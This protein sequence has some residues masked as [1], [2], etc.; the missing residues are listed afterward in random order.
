MKKFVIVDIDGTL[1]VPNPERMK[2]AH[3]DW[4]AFYAD[5][6]DDEP[7]KEMIDLVKHLHRKYEVVYCTARSERARVKTLN[8]FDKHEIPYENKNVLMRPLFDQRSSVEI[9]LELLRSKLS[10]IAIMFDDHNGIVRTFRSLGIVVL[11]PQN[12]NF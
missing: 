7:I 3:V 4:E 1:S 9:K 12:N 5:S 11:Q 10:K 6:F 2:H 8:W